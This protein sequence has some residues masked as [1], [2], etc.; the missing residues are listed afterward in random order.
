MKRNITAALIAALEV[1]T[2]PILPAATFEPL[3]MTGFNEDLVAEGMGTNALGTTTARFDGD[4]SNGRN[5]FYAQGFSSWLRGPGPRGLPA[6]GAFT[7][8]NNPNLRY[9]LMPYHQR[10]A[11]LLRGPGDTGSGG[12]AAAALALVW[13][14]SFSDLA[15]LGTS[16]MGETTLNYT[17]NFSDGTSF[18]ANYKVA[19]WC[20]PSNAVIRGFD[21]VCRDD[22]TFREGLNPT[23]PKLFEHIITL[24][25]ADQARTLTSISFQWIGSEVTRAAIFGLSG[26]AT[27]NQPP[28]VALTAPTNGARFLPGT[29]LVLAATATDSDGRITGVEFYDGNRLLG[30][31]TGAPYSLVLS[32]VPAGTYSFTARATDNRRK[33]T[34]SAPANI[35]V[36]P[37]S[38]PLV[39]YPN[40]SLTGGL[41]FQGDAAIAANR[42]R[43]TP[44]L[45]N[46]VGG[47]WL[48]AKQPVASGFE[49]M[50]QFQIT[51]PGGG[52]AEGLAFVIQNSSASALGETGGGLGYAGIPNS[53][54]VEFDLCQNPGQADPDGNHLGVHSGGHYPNSA[55]E[56]AALARAR[57]LPDLSDGNIHTAIL[58]Y[59]PGKLL[60]FLDNPAVPVLS[61]A[62]RLEE[63]LDLDAGGAWVGFTAATGQASENHDILMWSFRPELPPS[64]RLSQP[65]DNASF[66]APAVIRL[67]AEAGDADGGIVWL[68]YYANGVFLGSVIAPPFELIWSNAP[69]G[70]Y[71]LSAQAIDDF[72]AAMDSSPVTITVLEP[73]RIARIVPH[74]PA[75]ALLEFQT[76][77]GRTY[78]VEYSADL[79]NWQTASPVI[80][81]QG[82]LQQWLD[83]GPP[84]TGAGPLDHRFYRLVILP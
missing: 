77:P 45:T 16:A 5:V 39:F 61:V 12:A 24:S 52:G 33:T 18:S 1:L 55:F 37:E 9:Q 15:I 34:V 76:I 31:V 26:V 28:V 50:F 46:R 72:G 78:A 36:A 71:Q 38:A 58:R 74:P 75:M 51:E 83:V 43:L 40:F 65:L 35:A 19:D 41:A 54:A 7:N 82:G 79:V 47:A 25:P 23:N 57:N 80:T 44:A 29:N 73:P 32:N 64:V 49:T 2:T 13:P 20:G 63:L 70:S 22:D 17:L 6:S 42:L 10:N 30:R 68:D 62:L 59:V 21:R 4:I 3:P 84:G 56:G 8:V 66:F 48:A 14:D 53:L 60:V 67:T 27:P 81:G 69:A 11:L